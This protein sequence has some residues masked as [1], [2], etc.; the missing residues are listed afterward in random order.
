[1]SINNI[2]DIS[3]D[4]S[5]V[6][7][8]YKFSG[9]TFDNPNGNDI[10]QSKYMSIM[11]TSSDDVYTR[12]YYIP[13]ESVR[14]SINFTEDTLVKALFMIEENLLRK[15]YIDP[16]LSPG[17]E[18][19]HFK[20][21]DELSKIV[22]KENIDTPV[23]IMPMGED[24]TSIEDIFSIEVDV[25]DTIPFSEYNTQLEDRVDF[26]QPLTIDQINKNTPPDYI[27]FDEFSFAERLGTTA[28]RK[29]V[30][31]YLSAISHSTFSYFFQFRKLINL[32]LHELACIKNSLL[33]D[34]GD[35]YENEPQQ[36]IAVH[37]DT[38]SKMV[39]H[40]T[41]RITKTIGAQIEKLPTSEV[42]QVT[43]KQAAQFQA[44]F[45]VRLNA[46]DA[47]VDD[48]LDNLKRDLVDNCEIFYSRYLSPSL[49]MSTSVADPLELDFISTNF[50]RDC[51]N[52]AG[53]LVVATN[54]LRGNFVS[55]HADMVERIDMMT[56]RVDALFNLIH[57]KRRYSNY[58]S[59]LANV[60][61][62]KQKVLT[63][64]DLDLFSSFFRSATVDSTRNNKLGSSHSDLDDLDKDS[65]PQYLLKSGG[66]ITGN[67]YIEGEF[68]IDGISPSKHV[69]DG[70]DG[71]AKISILDIDFSTDQVD[72]ENVVIKPISVLIDGFIPD[73]L[74]GGVPVYD[75]IV[76]I[77]VSD[78]AGQNYDY[79]LVYTELD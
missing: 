13:L 39:L 56:V 38:W 21:W 28:G 50:V 46:V 37:Y 78:S 31:E 16:Y 3:N 69:H 48:I 26:S 55:I 49:A 8:D 4:A 73:I 77:E 59:Q 27:C 67:L 1:M 2:N 41:G 66:T 44:F 14:K 74:N 54:S 68:K 62:K 51:P 43:K 58:I 24:G 75:A 25:D 20:I 10:N 57:E 53:E 52:L 42:D 6:F 32:F 34:F 29:L 19:A 79:E 36:E 12:A 17:L 60:S 5:Q 7:A 64:V 70:S 45:A 72:Q 63:S 11:P 47:E 22:F 9:S 65:H 76:S 40:Y 33:L 61:V 15:I 23:S 35:Q 18:Q 71:S 30:S